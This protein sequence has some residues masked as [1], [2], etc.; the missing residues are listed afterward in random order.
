MSTTS[1]DWNALIYGSYDR[2][3]VIMA[4]ADFE[5][6]RLRR[7]LMGTSLEHKHAALTA[8]VAERPEHVRHVR[9]TNYIYA[10]KRAGRILKDV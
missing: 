9:V 3:T 4:V 6:Q 8:Y 10:L 1:L 7:S 5:W 2:N